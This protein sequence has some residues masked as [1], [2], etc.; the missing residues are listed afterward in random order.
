MGDLYV[1]VLGYHVYLEY[2]SSLK[3]LWALR[4]SRVKELGGYRATLGLGDCKLGVR[5]FQL[6]GLG[7]GFQR[8]CSGFRA[9]PYNS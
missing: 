3:P 8:W 2:F 6:L 1:N 4:A 5:D 9:M 7:F